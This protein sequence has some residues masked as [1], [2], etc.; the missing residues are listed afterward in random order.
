MAERVPFRGGLTCSCVVE[1]LPWVEKDLARL[2]LPSPVRIFQLGYR[3][4]VSASAGTH[5][6]GGCVDLDG[7]PTA[8]EI[9]VWRLWGWTM[10]ARFLS[11]VTPHCHGW[12]YKCTHLSA[13]AQ[14]QETDWNRKDAGL[15]GGA[16]V[17]GR[18][19]IKP[20]NI[21]LR[22]RKALLEEEDMPTPGEIA[23]AVWDTRSIRNVWGVGEGDYIRAE[24]ALEAIGRDGNDMQKR[25]DEVE[26]KLDQ[27]LKQ[28]P[29]PANLDD[30]E[31]I[32]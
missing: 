26:A 14:Q 16:Q 23:K 3:T 30:S 6:K 24:S 32:E 18:W 1:S 21:A 10:Q 31:G 25:M 12:P 28:Q 7:T 5:A 22:E 15:Q 20:W 29:A 8:A 27:L 9:D 2:G 11:G 13:A 4:D 17:Q 19:P